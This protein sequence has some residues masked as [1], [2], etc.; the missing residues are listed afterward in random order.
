[1]EEYVDIVKDAVRRK[2]KVLVPT[3]A[4][5]R[6]QL[7]LMLLSWMF[8]KGKVKPFPAFL[9]S[10]MAI[11][12]T[13]IY[14]RHVELFDDQMRS[15]MSERPVREDLKTLQATE[16]AD[17]SRAINSCPGPCLIMAGAGMCNAGR[18]LHHLRQN[19]WR[20]ET[21]VIIVG[22]QAAGSLGRRLVEG[23]RFVKILGEKIAVRARV[24][25]LG[26]FSAHAGQTDL[27]NWFDVIAP[28]RPRVIVC[29]GEDGPRKELARLIQG[30]HGLKPILPML[31][32]VVE[33]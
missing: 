27:L 2:G 24:H 28:S 18:I 1:V 25:T 3:F 14:T 19:L 6:A 15:Y 9:D 8:R 4:V 30:R 7:L 12:A 26:G 13:R 17:E 23:E 22:Y 16:S 21:H 31:K 11:E 33:L 32:D 5:G 10:P 29:H 20:P